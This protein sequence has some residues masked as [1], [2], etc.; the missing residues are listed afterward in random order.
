MDPL[1]SAV[2][3]PEHKLSE[4]PN[5][6]SIDIYGWT[7]TASTSPI[8]NAPELDALQT[9]L[10]FPPPEM[11]FG[12][13]YLS[14][15]HPP[16]GWKYS[17]TTGRALKQVKNGPLGEGDGGVKVGYADAWLQSRYESSSLPL[18]RSIDALLRTNHGSIL[19][20]PETVET[21]PYDWTYTTTYAGTS[22]SP[23]EDASVSSSTTWSPADPD[24][25]SHSI[26]LAELTRTDPI[27]FYAEVPLYEDELH[28]NGSSNLLVRIV[29]ITFFM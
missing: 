28:D 4:S 17:F 26:P 3:I 20:M 16:S 6:R 1:L 9:Y 21:R 22:S 27:L 12:N 2:A 23:F 24:N 11:T 15:E 13:N 19:M 14:L 7:V 25:P 18:Q 10:G 29:S 8:S 5:S